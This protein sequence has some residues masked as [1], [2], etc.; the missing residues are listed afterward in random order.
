VGA[1]HA[2]ELGPLVGLLAGQVPS[3]ATLRRAERAVDLAA[4]EAQIA[5][6]VARLPVPPAAPPAAR[7]PA[8]P[9]L[10]WVGLALDGK[11]MRGANSHGA[12]VY[13]G[14]LVRH[15]DGRVL[16]Q[17]AVSDKSNESTAALQLLAGQ[18]LAGTVTTMDA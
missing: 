1:E 5:A 14:G 3:A 12:R 8:V 17:V 13:L 16:G 7:F 2:A 11:A 18:D 6:F 4:L 9:S 10:P 15:D